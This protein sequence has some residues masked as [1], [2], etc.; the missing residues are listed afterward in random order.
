M[1]IRIAGWKRLYV[2]AEFEEE[3]L[4]LAWVECEFRTELS[5]TPTRLPREIELTEC[6]M[7][8]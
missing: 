4:C 6:W 5:E 3:D 8:L 2:V 7:I 1:L